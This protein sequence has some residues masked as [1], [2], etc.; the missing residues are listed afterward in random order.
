MDSSTLA[1]LLLCVVVNGAGFLGAQLFGLPVML[2]FTGS[3]IAAIAGGPL[4]TLIVSVLSGILFFITGAVGP[5]YLVVEILCAMAVAFLIRNKNVIH[6]GEIFMALGM[7]AAAAHTFIALAVKQ[8]LLW[9]EAEAFRA[10]AVLWLISETGISEVLSS[11]LVDFLVELLD[12]GLCV[13]LGYL[14]AYGFFRMGRGR[15][16]KGFRAAVVI[17]LIMI[18]LAGGVFGTVSCVEAIDIM[19]V[20]YNEDRIPVE[21]EIPEVEL[22]DSNCDAKNYKP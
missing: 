16:R 14:L 5:F 1:I 20:N 13:L 17:S 11:F 10:E 7:V 8:N 4:A 12:K 3:F 21:T 22:D 18:I 2:D 9:S 19:P 6:A 15:K